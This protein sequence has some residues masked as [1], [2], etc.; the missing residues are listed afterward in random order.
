MVVGVVCWRVSFVGVGTTVVLLS[1]L[2]WCYFLLY[3][4]VC[5]LSLSLYFELVE[6]VSM[7]IICVLSSSLCYYCFGVGCL[8]VATL[9]LLW[10]PV[11][12]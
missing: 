9:S 6:Y 2:G 11:G 5:A 3:L 4:F 7:V 10:A 1:C 12:G 8:Y